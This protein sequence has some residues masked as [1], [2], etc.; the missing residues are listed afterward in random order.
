LLRLRHHADSS[1]D[2]PDT[3]CRTRAA[4]HSPRS[5]HYFSDQREECRFVPFGSLLR[6]LFVV[7]GEDELKLVASE[8]PYASIFVHSAVLRGDVQPVRHCGLVY[9]YEDV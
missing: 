1:A 9:C 3:H 4:V 5:G 2:G 7:G 6:L 8:D